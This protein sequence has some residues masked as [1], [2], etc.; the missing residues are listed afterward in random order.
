MFVCAWAARA[1][2]LDDIITCVEYWAVVVWGEF[3]ERTQALII[4]FINS[5]YVE[6]LSDAMRR[7]RIIAYYISAATH[8]APYGVVAMLAA[9]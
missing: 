6:L 4:I 7:E 3:L 5:V 8:S 1:A 9:A 2:E